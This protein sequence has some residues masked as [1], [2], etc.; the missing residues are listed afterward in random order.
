[1]S[2]RAVERIEMTVDLAAA[3][4][5]AAAVGFCVVSLSRL[6]THPQ[7]LGVT[8]AASVAAFILCGL[9]L[10]LVRPTR[11]ALT[12]PHFEAVRGI[13]PIEL[14][15]LLLTDADRLH[16]GDDELVLTDADRL[17][18]EPTSPLELDDILARIGPD[19]R[20][21]RLFDPAA[22]PT[23]GQLKTRIDRHLGEDAPPTG[24]EDAS[25]ALFEALAQLRRS[26]A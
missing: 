18:P 6:P 2:G 12:M 23:P 5:F 4:L 24:P 19:S 11:R 1:M 21:V 10:R 16:P 25:Q 13:D 8:V 26:L 7:Q 14:D 15:E 22:M 17:R 3:A 9:P 20:V